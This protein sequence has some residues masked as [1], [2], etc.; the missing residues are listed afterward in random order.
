MFLS[1]KQSN[2]QTNSQTKEP[3]PKPTTTNKLGGFIDT[4]KGT[5]LNGDISNMVLQR[6]DDVL[7]PP[8]AVAVSCVEKWLCNPVWHGI[9]PSEKDRLGVHLLG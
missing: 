9:D 5:S 2:K 3:T 6:G 8:V 7:V 4:Y 1:S